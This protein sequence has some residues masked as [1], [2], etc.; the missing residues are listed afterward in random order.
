MG[1]KILTDN[2]FQSEAVIH[3]WKMCT[4]RKTDRNVDKSGMNRQRQTERI[5]QTNVNMLSEVNSYN[6]LNSKQLNCVCM[7]YYYYDLLMLECL[8]NT[9][10]ALS[11]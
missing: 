3:V 9:I 11:K 10:M 4:K 5:I 6:F 2:C 1:S 8:C 7:G